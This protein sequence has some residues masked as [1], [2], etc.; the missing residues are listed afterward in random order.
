MVVAAIFGAAVLCAVLAWGWQGRYGRGTVGAGIAF[1]QANLASPLDVLRSMGWRY[2]AAMGCLL[3]LVGAVWVALRRLAWPAVKVLLC[4]ARKLVVRLA[5]QETD[6]REAA[7]RGVA[8]QHLRR[9]RF[10]QTRTSGWS[11]KVSGPIGSELGSTRSLARTEQPWTHPEVVA[12]LR[13]FLDLVVEV[14]V[15]DGEKLSGIVVAIDELDKIADSD[16]AQ[17]FLNEI[18]GIFGVRRCLFLVSASEDALTAFERRG[19][20]ARDAFDSTFTTMDPRC[21][22]HDLRI[23][24]LAG[25]TCTGDTRTVRVVVPLSVRRPA[26]RSR[27][28]RHRPARPEGRVSRTGGHDPRA[29]TARADAESPGVHP[30]GRSTQPR[31]W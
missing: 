30:H 10:L 22:L 3:L 8:L 14:L 16:D 23:A 12:R 24:N 9:I 29:G 15:V 17:R 25:T 31:R 6:P 18:K 1:V 4:A 27:T 13:D 19:M 21:S 20:P 7:L 28:C 26:A 5:R 11:G 2:G